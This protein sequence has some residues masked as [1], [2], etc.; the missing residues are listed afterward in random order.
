MLPS[1]TIFFSVHSLS[2]VLAIVLE[3]RWAEGDSFWKSGQRSLG[4]GCCWHARW[5]Y[6]ERHTY[7]EYSTFL[8][9]LDLLWFSLLSVFKL[10]SQEEPLSS[11]PLGIHY[12]MP[13]PIPYLGI[14]SCA[15]GE[16]LV[17]APTFRGQGGPWA[18][19]WGLGRE[20][21]GE[22]RLLGS[23]HSWFTG[24]SAEG[25]GSKLAFA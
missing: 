17:H 11:D 7:S 25:S 13:A 9:E 18:W 16:S 6:R 4:V 22:Q 12:C 19:H 5:E 10:L 3:S 20:M 2:P 21:A 23:S 8:S 24:P 1:Q 15:T 14:F